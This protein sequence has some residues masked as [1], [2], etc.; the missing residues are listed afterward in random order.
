MTPDLHG[1]GEHVKVFD[2][3]QDPQPDTPQPQ[4]KPIM[5]GDLVESALTAVGIT[6]ERVERLTRTAGKP[7][8]CGCDGRKR[9]LN[10]QGVKVQ[11]A[12]RE[13]AQR[14]YGVG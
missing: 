1:L 7:G 3:I 8:E 10:E 2:T 4:W 9:W 11:K 12:I 5:V 6:R 14:A 13:A